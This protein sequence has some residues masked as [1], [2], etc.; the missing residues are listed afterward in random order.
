MD[1]FSYQIEKNFLKGQN[2]ILISKVGLPEN[3]KL[4][5]SSAMINTETGE[6]NAKDTKFEAFKNIFGNSD[7]DPR[8]KGVSSKGTKNVKI[9][10]KGI[11]TS[12]KKNDNCP[13]WSVKAKKITHDRNKKQLIY[14]NAVLKIY[15]FPI[16][17]FPKFFHPDLQSKDNRVS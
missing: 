15:D 3:E 6:F 17:Y 8:I 16:L 7:N 9:I 4:Y 5:F 14:D 1:N 10:N 2:I 11:F 12:C 13:P